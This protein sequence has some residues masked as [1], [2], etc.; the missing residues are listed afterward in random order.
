M[1][2]RMFW[3]LDLEAQDQDYCSF[4]EL[5]EKAIVS[6]E[7]LDAIADLELGMSLNLEEGR[8]Q[9]VRQE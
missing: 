7:E 3:V 5:L 1:A 9:I 2:K 4:G 8:V 6:D